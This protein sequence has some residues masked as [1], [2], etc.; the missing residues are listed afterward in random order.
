MNSIALCRLG[1][2][3]RIFERSP[4]PLLHDQG[5]GIVAGG[6]TQA[7]MHTYDRSQRPIA[8]QS[9]QRL[10]LEKS[11]KI[12]QHENTPQRMTSWDLLYYLC[13]ANFDLVQS[14]YLQGRSIPKHPTDGK[15]EYEYGR[16][17]TNVEQSDD[18]IKVTY[19]STRESEPKSEH[20]VTADFVVLADGPSSHSRKQLSPSSAS[21]TYAGYVA[22]RGTV[23]ENDLSES[24]AS[25]FVEKFPFFHDAGTQILAYTIPGENGSVT[26]DH[27]KVNWVWYVNVTEGSEE[28]KGI[29][30]DKSGATH[31]WTLPPGGTMRSEVWDAQIRRARDTLPPQYI[32]LVEKT[33]MPF[34]Q[35]ITDLPPPADGKCWVLGGKGVLVGDALSGFRPHTAASTSQAAL[36]A[37]LLPRVLN[38]KIS[39]EEYEKEVIGFAKSMQRHGVMLGNRSQFGS[40]PL[41]G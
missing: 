17:V 16:F 18:Q 22:F 8:V 38:G 1:H 39:K 26:A 34:V 14:D 15:A 36:H 30:T 6:E 41:R 25:I 10:Y 35:A 5:A 9:H 20:A 11:G 28:Y 12:L 13:R 4:T 7:F 19:H 21:R 2:N 23:A 29:M 3:V 40:H 31:Q 33:K 32:E 37:L 27:R 24:A